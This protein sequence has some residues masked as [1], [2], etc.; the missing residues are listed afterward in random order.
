LA[1]GLTIERAI[2]VQAAVI[3]LALGTALD[4]SNEGLTQYLANFFDPEAGYRDALGIL[5]AGLTRAGV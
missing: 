3:S 2:A 1:F 5:A 4:H